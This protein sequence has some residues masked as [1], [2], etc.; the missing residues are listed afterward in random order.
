VGADLSRPL[1]Q[2]FDEA[3]RLAPEVT[4]LRSRTLP[5]ET[6]TFRQANETARDV[7]RHLVGLGVRP[8][9]RVALV[10]EN[11]PRWCVAYAG[12]LHAAAVVVPLDVQAP[13]SGLARMLADCGARAVIVSEAMRG[14]VDEAFLSLDP[15]P[16]VLSL[17]D[18]PGGRTWDAWIA[19][20]PDVPL[21][22]PRGGDAP[23]AILYTSGT[24]G[25]PKGVVLTHANLWAE[26]DAVSAAVRFA[27]TDRLIMFLPLQ[28]V[29]SQVGSFLL[30]ATVR[31]GVVHASV[32]RGEELLQAVREEGVTILLAVP[33]LYHLLHARI[34]RGLASLAAPLRWTL[35]ALR[36]INGVLPAPVRRRVGRLVFARVHG[37]FGPQVRL[38]V[39]GG[40][41]L[42]PGVQRDFLAMGL[43]LAQAYGL[44]ETAGGSTFSDVAHVVVGTV[45]KALPGVSV[46]IADPDAS[47]AGEVLLGGPTVTAG[48]WAKPTATHELLRDGWLHT[49]DLGRLDARGNLAITGRL[50]DVI[51]LGSGKNVY[52]EEVES[53]Y[54]RCAHVSEACV[55][56]VPAPGGGEAL[57]AVIVPDWERLREDG[58]TAV[59]DRLRFEIENAS[60]ELPSWQRAKSFEIR[61]DPLPRTATRKLQRFLVRRGDGVPGEHGTAGRADD[62][63]QAARLESPE[64]RAVGGA[65][66][67]RLGARA[68]GLR[69]GAS[70][71]LDLGLDSLTRMEVLLSVE[72]ELGV[73]LPEDL[74]RG[75]VTVDDLVRA[76]QERR[77]RA[78]EPMA[79]TSWTDVVAAAGPADL[80]DWLL[81]T[82]GPVERGALFLAW[83]GARFLAR[84]LFRLRVRGQEHL[85]PSGA[86]L[87]C[88]NHV[89]WLDG[90]LVGC[91]L[92]WSHLERAFAF[93]E[94]AYVSGGLVEVLARAFGVVPTDANTEVGRT[95]RA[96]AAGLKAGRVLM[97]FPEGV[98]SADGS[99][100]QVKLGAPILAAELG[101]PVVPVVLRGAF[102]AWPRGRRLPRPHPIDV[103]FGA[104]IV[105]ARVAPIDLPRDTRYR[106]LVDALAAALGSSARPGSGSR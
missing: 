88:P 4:Y 76:L 1:A 105:P 59:R 106:R 65:L 72:Q 21:P 43:P 68:E 44:T 57:H 13:A 12:V 14:R 2:L 49:G 45:G 67:A 42:D 95:M 93:G 94:R 91:A 78:A 50:K 7:A 69:G 27:P 47:G 30:P 96:G 61:R 103:D 28:H 25:E 81:R 98:R 62:A 83:C 32:Q 29:L 22:E 6:F 71:E 18:A 64:G 58:I 3:A 101:V 40:A 8:G 97:L 35:R 99:L 60:L 17:D 10:A 90:F 53:H 38:L 85:P 23:A 73:A 41:A 104:P 20:D 102:E 16:S 77:G 24:T 39:S 19:G 87:L 56:G 51:V 92:P 75:L 31:T 33:L 5:R 26:L 37:L 11:R 70:L 9:D 74:A 100:Q 15:R 36:R 82:R 89:S 34:E 46:R 63:A 80:P 84:L 54:G 48:Y 86:Y 55:L 79:V 66:R 52:P